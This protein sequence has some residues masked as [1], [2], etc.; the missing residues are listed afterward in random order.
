MRLE[1]DHQAAL[2]PTRAGRRKYRFEF[3]R[4]MAV[5]VD[6]QYLAATGHILERQFAE[7]IETSTDALEGIERVRD[8]RR[9]HAELP[10]DRGRGQCVLHIVATRHIQ[11]HSAA[12]RIR[13]TQCE[14]GS[15]SLLMHILGTHVGL[16]SEAVAENVPWHFGSQRGDFGVVDA[17]HRQ[18]VERQPV[19]EFGERHA[20][21]LEIAAVIL[22]MVGV[23]IGDHRDLRI[24]AQ[25][26]AVAFVC[27]GD[28]PVAAAEPRVGADRQQ[29]PADHEGG[30][31]AAFREHAGDQRGRR[32][33]AVGAGHRDPALEAHQLRQHFRARHHRNAMR[34]RGQQLDVVDLDRARHHNHVGAVDMRGIVTTLYAGTELRKPLRYRRIGHVRT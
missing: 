30:I 18:P 8:R 24:Q 15:A 29:L 33:L 27:F 23:D 4:M 11:A 7:Q 25:E 9:R 20:H 31:H 26:A 5:I 17:Q 6:Q 21:A 16:R 14:V 3:A 19:Q 10:A 13:Q 32:G 2:G 22:Q 34:A 12:F 1:P 28:Q